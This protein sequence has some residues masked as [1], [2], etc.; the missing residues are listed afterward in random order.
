MFY[1]A[2]FQKSAKF[3]NMNII[4]C[5]NLQEPKHPR[6][7]NMANSDI[8]IFNRAQRTTISSKN[9]LGIDGSSLASSELVTDTNNALFRIP[10]FLSYAAPL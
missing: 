2:F 7:I 8:E 5:S 6:V 10:V 9:T 1:R 3:M 4:R